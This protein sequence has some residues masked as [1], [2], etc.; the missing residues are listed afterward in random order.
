[1]TDACLRAASGA[2]VPV[3]ING[4]AGVLR[5]KFASFIHSPR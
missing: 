4:P 5:L 2:V 3:Q 1:M